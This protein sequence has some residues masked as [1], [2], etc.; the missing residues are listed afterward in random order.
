MTKWFDANYHYVVPEIGA[1]PERLDPLP[2]RT[3]LGG[4]DTAWVI[5]GP[6]S[7]VKLSK[8]ADGVDPVDLASAAGRAVWAFV[9]EE[10]QRDPAS[11]QVDEPSLGMAMTDDDRRLLDT[12]YAD[13]PD[14]GLAE[15]PLVTVQFGRPSAETVLALGRRGLAVQVPLDAVA[16][17][18][19]TDAWRAQPEHVIS[20]VDGRSVWSDDFAGVRESIGTIPDDGKP[21]RLVPSA[22]FLFLPYTVVGEDLPPGFAFAREKTAALASWAAAFSGGD[23][24]DARRPPAAEWPEIGEIRARDGRGRSRPADLDLPPSRN[25]T[26]RCR[27]RRGPPAAYDCRAAISIA[28]LRGRVDASSPSGGL[29]EPPGS[30]PRAR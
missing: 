16:E 20:V 21:V 28:R 2:W 17:L 26:G 4:G 11:P 30:R 9:R 12:A 8:V 1:L 19:A 22:S 29:A 23:A 10:R 24:V 14:L 27:R 13:A 3:P 5:L 7:L 6:Y 18:S 15:T 25:D